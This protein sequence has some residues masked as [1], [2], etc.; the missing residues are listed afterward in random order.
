MLIAD[1]F[2]AQNWAAGAGAARS[3]KSGHTES[4]AITASGA[5]P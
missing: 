5:D 1:Y 4:G 3:D 2:Y